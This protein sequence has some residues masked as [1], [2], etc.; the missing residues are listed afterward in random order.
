MQRP[1]LL[2]SSDWDLALL[3]TARR[4]WC[5]QWNPVPGSQGMGMDGER[6]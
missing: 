5:T 3:S 6:K 1:E 4:A 2:Q